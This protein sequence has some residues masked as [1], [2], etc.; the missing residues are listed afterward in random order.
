[1]EQAFLG[2]VNSKHFPGAIESVE[3]LSLLSFCFTDRL[4]DV[5]FAGFASTKIGRS[6]L[7]FPSR[8]L[9][10]PW[11][12]KPVSNSQSAAFAWE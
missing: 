2:E 10:L 7:T 4:F 1:V 3:P 5:S 11:P 6:F 8:T 12:P 9:E